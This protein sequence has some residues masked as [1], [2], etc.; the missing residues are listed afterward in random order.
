MCLLPSKYRALRPGLR[1]ALDRL[2]PSEANALAMFQ[3][4]TMKNTKVLPP[5]N[6]PFGVLIV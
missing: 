4:G 1:D 5:Q 3:K 6:V 2:P